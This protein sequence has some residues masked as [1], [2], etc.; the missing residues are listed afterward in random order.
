MRN[1]AQTV[2]R[3][4]SAAVYKYIQI[5]IINF[6]AGSTQNKHI[7]TLFHDS[8][9]WM[10]KKLD[11][12]DWL[13]WN[14]W[15]FCF[16]LQVMK[17]S[18][19]FIEMNFKLTEKFWTAKWPKRLKRRKKTVATTAVTGLIALLFLQN[20][21][22]RLPEVYTYKDENIMFWATM[23]PQIRFKFF[24]CSSL[25]A[26]GSSDTTLLV[27]CYLSGKSDSIVEIFFRRNKRP[28]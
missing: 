23:G 16:R 11:G 3:F 28:F 13:I 7:A 1:K 19:C 4:E 17:E 9:F 22:H 5:N 12:N 2:H 18:I 25:A 24:C 14:N 6:H 15:G 21:P 27:G 10:W 26:F 8:E 20:A